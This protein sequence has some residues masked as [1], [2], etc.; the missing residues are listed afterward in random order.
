MFIYLNKDFNKMQKEVIETALN[1]AN[2]KAEIFDS[3]LE[4]FC[5]DEANN[6]REAYLIT[7][8]DIELSEEQ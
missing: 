8:R 6:M 7:H 3:G 2:L 5:T 4:A 1:K